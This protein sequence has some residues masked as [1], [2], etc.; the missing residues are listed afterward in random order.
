M[1]TSSSSTDIGNT[2]APIVTGPASNT[3]LPAV[4]P[5]TSS[6]TRFGWRNRLLFLS[7]IALPNRR[8]ESPG[9][10]DGAQ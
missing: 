8:T 2:G 1:D 10:Q 3:S 9:E 7:S 4:V 6:V 5:L